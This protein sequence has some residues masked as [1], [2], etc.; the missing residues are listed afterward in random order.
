M[1]DQPTER[2]ILP[3]ALLMHFD[4]GTIALALAQALR[5]AG[6]PVV[7]AC[8]AQEE[9]RKAQSA[10]LFSVCAP[11]A[12]QRC[13]AAIA[14]LDSVGAQWPGYVLVDATAGYSVPD[15][16][17]VAEKMSEQP[18]R[19]VLA[20]RAQPWER[21]MLFRRER[22]LG[23]F[24]FRALHGLQVTDPWCTLRGI[25]RAFAREL[26]GKY[27]NSR[28]FWLDML[29]TLRRRGIQTACV[30]IGKP[31][32]RERGATTLSRFA[33]LLRIAEQ[34]LRYVASSLTVML[35]DTGLFSLFFYVILNGNRP[36]SLAIGRLTGA[37]LGYYLNRSI[38][39]R[40]K[41]NSWRREAYTAGKYAVLVA[42]N[43]G[44][45]LA[46]N[47]LIASGL[48]HLFQPKLAVFLSKLLADLVLYI[49]TFLVNREVVFRKRRRPAKP[50]RPS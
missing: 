20:E 45:A 40:H 27:E 13:E 2:N 46:L 30:P 12:R 29:L 15:V 19:L 24:L 6:M 17:A 22:R 25:P 26:L 39:F 16:L 14:L 4:G 33:D 9:A 41:K 8:G 28:R 32:R 3:A 23:S 1:S 36:V 50:K 34:M 37:L 10:R 35:V 44:L 38:V 42:V 5:D 43:Y 49:F 31:Y 7:A 48:L 18:D 47:Y 11:D 21:G